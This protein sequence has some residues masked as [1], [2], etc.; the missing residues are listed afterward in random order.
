M[1]VSVGLEGVSSGDVAWGDYDSDGDLDVLLTGQPASGGISRV[2]RNDGA[3]FTDVGAGLVG[4]AIGRAAW[5]DYD[6]DG[7]LDIL[8]T[9]ASGSGTPT[10]RVYRNDGNGF[11]DI[12]VGLLACIGTGA[13]GDFD[14]DGDLDILLGGSTGSTRYTGL[15]RNLCSVGN[16]IPSRPLNLSSDLLDSVATFQWDV[17]TDDETPSAGLTYNLR[18]GTTR[19]GSEVMSGMAA[20]STGYRRVVQLGNAQKRTSWT[21]QLPPGVTT[22]Y[23][24]VQA[25]DGAYAGGA[26]APEQTFSVSTGIEDLPS[27]G[28]GILKAI[29]PNPFS[30]ATVVRYELP[31]TSPVEIAILD[32]TGRLVRVLENRV[33]EAGHHEIT[34]DG[35]RADGAS[36]A[37]GV[38]LCRLRAGAFQEVRRVVMLE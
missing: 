5:G 36:A 4:L 14:N 33:M 10:S 19:G 20:T 15:Y 16:T 28:T 37:A 1:S 26:F 18:I 23:W 32:V 2:Y 3:T 9:G 29:A 22:G 35:R 24:S 6:N 13:W 11:S 38:Y 17:A 27:P 21:V 30:R 8:L 25:I 31:A 7:D 12:A 34:W